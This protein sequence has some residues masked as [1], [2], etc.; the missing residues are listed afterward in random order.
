MQK[1]TPLRK[2]RTVIRI[3][4]ET[5]KEEKV[6]VEKIVNK[7]DKELMKELDKAISL[8]NR[9]LD[10]LQEDGTREYLPHKLSYKETKDRIS[11][12]EELRKTINSLKAFTKE[13]AE[14]F[15]ELE[16]NRGIT[17]WEQ[18][19]LKHSAKIVK[20]RLEKEIEE[21]YKPVEGAGGFSRAQ[22][23]SKELKK[24]EEKLEYVKNVEK[25][26]VK[27]FELGK[28]RV[29]AL[30]ASDY[31]YRKAWQYRKNYVETIERFQNFD[32]YK[33]LK[34]EFKKRK[35]PIT[36]WNWMKNRCDE[37]GNINIIDIHFASNQQFTQALFYTFL[38]DIGVEYNKKNEVQ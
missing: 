7:I 31:E 25:G 24:K 33:E 19:K 3:N 36:F 21:Y 22:M 27:N 20:E 4:Q 16:N 23:G 14:E 37:K 10:R 29:F 13:G 9:K 15:I 32:G 17:K 30:G 12:R 34:E 5:G 2:E 35:N 11:T 1:F 38:D 28:D 26:R 18:Q 6:K 8:F